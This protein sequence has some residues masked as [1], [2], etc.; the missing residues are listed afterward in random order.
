MTRYRDSW[1][2]QPRRLHE[3]IKHSWRKKKKSINN[4][5]RNTLATI[6]HS[7]TNTP[8]ETGGHTGAPDHV[9]VLS[10]KIM[11]VLMA[12][13]GAPDEEGRWGRGGGG[14]VSKLVFYA[15][16]TITVI[17]GREGGSRKSHS[18]GAV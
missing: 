3:G 1:P 7:A 13:S 14:G 18:S 9:N 15:K 16:S 12:T 5:I 8:I 4:V 10:R 17:S 11:K 2:R 6:S